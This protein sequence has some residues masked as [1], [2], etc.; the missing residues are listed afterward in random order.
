MFRIVVDENISF[1][2]EAFSSLGEV[3]LLHGRK[4]D[5]SALKDADA[6]VI[7]S[8]T[9][10]NEELLKDTPVKFVGTATIGTDHVDLD[11]LREKGIAFSSAKGCNADAVAEYVF[12]ALLTIAMEKDI[13]LRAK[14][15]GVIGVGNIGSRVVRYGKALGMNVL[16]NDPP[17][18]RRSMSSEFISLEEALKADIVTFHVPLNMEGEDKTYHMLN[19]ENLKLIKPGAILIN[20]SR[21]QV[22]DNKALLEFLDLRKDLSV[23]LD[24]W[25]HE[26]SINSGLL[27]KTSLASPHIAGYSLEGKVNGT[28]IIRDA[29]CSF[30]KC[31][32]SYRPVFPETEDAVIDTDGSLSIESIL[33][34][35]FTKVYNIREDNRNM[36][37]IPE[38]LPEEKGF[39]F[40]ELR[41]HY[42]LRR[43]F[44]NYSV[45]FNPFNKTA[46]EVLKTFRFSVSL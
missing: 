22:I 36:R 31:N 11:Y 3:R 27:E 35:V 34:N 29:L 19:E 17:L 9:N 4:I 18:K 6:L 24:V 32:E 23:V 28:V 46:A 42:R 13:V 14:T 30:L 20:A 8:I 7:R 2:E 38:L 33:F 25:E 39:Y 45:K 12:T 37:R 43:E 44:S 15:L 21:G 26:P 1:A 10:V 41:K 5:R 40:D 16:M